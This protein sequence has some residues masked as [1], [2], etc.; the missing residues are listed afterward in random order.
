MTAD[1]S[2]FKH[3]SIFL[4]FFWIFIF[5]LLPA[6]LIFFTSFLTKDPQYLIQWKWTLENYRD[7]VNPVFFK[8][9]INS[10]FYAFFTT[11][12]CLLISYPFSFIISRIQNRYKK[13]LLV[14]IIIPFWTSSLIR[15]YSLIILFKANGLLNMLLIKLH[16]IQQ[17][18]NILYTDT[19][20][21]W[22]LVYTLLPF[23]ILPIYTAIDKL[24][25]RLIE[26]AY[27]LG[28]GTFNVFIKVV[29]PLTIPGVIAGCT[30]VFIPSL[31]LFFIPDILGGAKII[32]IGNYIKNQFL[33][34]QDW[35]KGAASSMV[36]VILLGLFLWGY[37]KSMNRF[38]V[39]PME[40]ER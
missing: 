3:I 19:A 5:V 4:V 11:L 10:L 34:I 27:D 13:L 12:F 32:L 28:A 20:V 31:G 6:L 23:M 21:F 2:W 14:L 1:K 36:L 37:F 30:M 9:F 39:S 18:L 17:P 15:T 8:I 16:L 38:N 24:D 26:A 29:F 22:G 33:T 35:P 40:H 25:N 7:L